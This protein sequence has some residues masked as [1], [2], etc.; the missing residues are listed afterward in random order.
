MLD[1]LDLH[2]RRLTFLRRP[3]GPWVGLREL[4]IF[5]AAYLTYFGVRAMTE[6]SIPQ[7]LANAGRIAHVERLA[8][9]DWEGAAQSAILGHDAL[10][11]LA[12]W[13]YIFGHW[14]VLLL[15]GVLLF[16]YRRRE[17]YLLR[18][19]CLISGAIGL[20]I[21]ALFPVAPP[22][23]AG[24]GV[25]DTITYY[26]GGYRT[27]LPRS[28]VNEYAAMPS[29]HAG[30][31]VLLGIVLFRASSRWPLRAFAL[32]MPTAMVIAVVV[33]ANHF[34]LDVLV[35]TAI[36]LAALTVVDRRNRGRQAPTLAADGGFA[37]H[38]IARPSGAAGHPAVRRRSP[39]G[40]D[41]D[42]LQRAQ[43]LGIGVV[44]ADLHLY[45][46]RIEVRHLKTLGPVPVLWDRW[47][48][49]P[50]WA[51]RLRLDRLLASVRPGTE[52]ILDL[53]GRDP[54]LPALV[55]AALG[56]ARAGRADDRLRTP[57]A[58][59]ASSC[60]RHPDV[61]PVH[62]VGARRQLRPCAAAST[63]D[64]LHGVSIHRKLLDAAT[65]RRPAAARGAGHDVAGADTPRQV[66]RLVGWGVR[67]LITDVP[68]L[69]AA[70][71]SDIGAV[72]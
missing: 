65:V 54:R 19:V 35:G 50:P 29:F 49:A 7:A 57:L 62:S 26:A 44:E 43:A 11:R 45:A 58:P 23:L 31:S 70:E 66:R 3:R 28:L 24:A 46:G 53:K 14:P 22:R 51:P 39:C 60:S 15:A 72:A 4:A 20:V 68:E 8:G 9:V 67:G 27:V 63:A 6:G 47:T 18:D 38:R 59:A 34:V 64:R 55:A 61:R 52:L 37:D 40:N 36:V 5:A 25:V 32:L 16:R 17:Y 69:V 33:T 13:V 56:R 10:V 2:A 41:L 42:C 21:F 30:W 48:L 12:N 1:P 71:L